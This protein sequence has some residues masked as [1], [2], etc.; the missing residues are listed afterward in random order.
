LEAV[1]Q[2]LSITTFRYIPS[3]LRTGSHKAVAYL[4]QLN[5]ELLN[6]LQTGGEVF[7]SN[8]IVKGQFLLRA[9]VVNFRTSLSDIRAIPDI[10]TRIGRVVDHESRPHIGGL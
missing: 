8:A 5:T 1:T 6:R 10:V 3:D 9:C 4:N 2:S 7:L